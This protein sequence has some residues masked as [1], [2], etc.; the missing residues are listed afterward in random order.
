MGERDLKKIGKNIYYIKSG[1]PEVY[2]EYTIM[3]N[4]VGFIYKFTRTTEIHYFFPVEGF[5][6]HTCELT[7]TFTLLQ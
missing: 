2:D 3:F 1:K 7:Q 5:Y 6:M 4:E